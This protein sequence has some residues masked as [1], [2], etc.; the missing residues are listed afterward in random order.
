MLP[1]SSQP[2]HVNLQFEDIDGPF[3]SAFTATLC[4]MTP[5]VHTKTHDGPRC[6]LLAADLATWRGSVFVTLGLCEEALA[7]A[8]LDA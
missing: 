1:T 8:C 4:H 2:R 7:K 5:C 3:S 6:P